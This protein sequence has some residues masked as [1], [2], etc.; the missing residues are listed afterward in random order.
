MGKLTKYPAVSTLKR[1]F[2]YDPDTGALYRLRAARGAAAGEIK[3]KSR[4]VRFRDKNMSKMR[5]AY[6]L[7]TGEDAPFELCPH[8]GDYSNLKWDNITAFYSEG[9]TATMG[10]PIEDSRRAVGTASLFVGM[11][12]C[13]AIGFMIGV[14]V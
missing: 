7:M 1:N 3:T 13:L 11:A 8:D 9:N 10:V 6:K 2:L 5:L 4:A 14:F 12:A